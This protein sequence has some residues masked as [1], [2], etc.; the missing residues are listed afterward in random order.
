MTCGGTF[1]LLKEALI[2]FAL[3]WCSLTTWVFV[4]PELPMRWCWCWMCPQCIWGLVVPCATTGWGRSAIVVPWGMNTSF[5]SYEEQQ[6][7]DTSSVWE[8]WLHG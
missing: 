5:P 6:W 3:G 4:S 7:G 1:Y 8:S 2:K